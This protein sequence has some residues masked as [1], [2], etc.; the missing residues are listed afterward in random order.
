[1]ATTAASTD[2]FLASP[3]RN[4]IWIPMDLYRKYTES[5]SSSSSSPD[6][7]S[8]SCNW[9]T[10]S[11][12]KAKRSHV[13]PKSRDSLHGR[14]S[15]SRIP[16]TLV[17]SKVLKTRSSKQRSTLYSPSHPLPSVKEQLSLPIAS[18]Y[19]TPSPE[20]QTGATTSVTL[21]TTAFSSHSPPHDLTSTPTPTI[22]GLSNVSNSCSSPPRKRVV[23]RSQRVSTACKR[24]KQSSNAQPDSHR[25][26]LVPPKK[27]KRDHDVSQTNTP[28]KS[29]SSSPKHHFDKSQE[30]KRLK[31]SM[32]E[33]AM[34]PANQR[35]S[36]ARAMCQPEVIII[37]DDEADDVV[38]IV[39]DD[40][41]NGDDGYCAVN[42]TAE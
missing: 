15:S 16:S 34:T 29:Q 42:S 17:Q 21:L 12:S 10:G 31:L 1:M 38:L 39:S 18:P 9:H 36:S 14:Q 41:D 40:D 28:P 33:T 22:T 8:S 27:R 20:S 19:P 25:S 32:S 24:A 7:S 35:V 30:H 5:S 4:V 26:S 3:R 2:H 13:L 37:S 23:S 6:L 11:S